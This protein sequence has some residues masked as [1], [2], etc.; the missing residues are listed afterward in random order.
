MIYDTKKGPLWVTA[1]VAEIYQ[2][3]PTPLYVGTVRF[4]SIKLSELISVA[5]GDPKY[6]DW[7]H[8]TIAGT[9]TG[10][11]LLW[12]PRAELLSSFTN[13]ES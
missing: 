3:S 13:K 7:D 2:E 5:D 6:D 11:Y 12:V 8:V 10:S 9:R 4:R 1:R